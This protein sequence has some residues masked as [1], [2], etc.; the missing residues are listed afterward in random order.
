M[1]S[2]LWASCSEAQV[3]RARAAFDAAPRTNARVVVMHHNL[4]R[5][6]LSHRY[7]LAHPARAA[8]GLAALGIDLILC[9]H[10]H[11]EAVHV[12][13]NGARGTVVS[14]AGTMSSR[15][16]G[17]RPSSVNVITIAPTEITV[18]VR[19]WDRAARDFVPGATK[20]FAR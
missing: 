1:I 2:A 4:V 16:R 10:D 20:T 15:S 5:G 12:V 14:T 13:P 8:S 18:D 7:G 19:M 9:G 6:D 17:H 3:D 11:Q